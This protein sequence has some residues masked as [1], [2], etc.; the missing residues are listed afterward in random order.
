V[1]DSGTGVSAECLLEFSLPRAENVTDVSIGGIY[2]Q[3][4]GISH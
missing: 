1:I 3:Q 2:E 4:A